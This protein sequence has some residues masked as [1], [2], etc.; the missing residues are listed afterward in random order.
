LLFVVL[1]GGVV[2]LLGII[3]R[4]TVVLLFGVVVLRVIGSISVSVVDIL[5]FNLNTLRFC[6][7]RSVL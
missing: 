5:R 1:R 6:Y 7:N 3:V 2:L 4:S